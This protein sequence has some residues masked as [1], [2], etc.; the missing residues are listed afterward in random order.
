VVEIYYVD[1]INFFHLINFQ[2]VKSLPHIEPEVWE[3]FLA[4][5]W[6]YMW[7]RCY[8]HWKP[9][10]IIID[11]MGPNCVSIAFQ[12]RPGSCCVRV[13]YTWPPSFIAW[14]NSPRPRWHVTNP[15]MI[16]YIHYTLQV[17]G[18]KLVHASKSA[19]PYDTLCDWHLHYP[20]SIGH[21]WTRFW[22][23]PLG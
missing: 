6:C 2:T 11:I 20:I 18:N 8:A 4:L 12:A 7:A 15:Y 23:I 21:F 3:L 13:A 19:Q 22:F 10:E 17:C 5:S 1:M 16:Y 9:A 14:M